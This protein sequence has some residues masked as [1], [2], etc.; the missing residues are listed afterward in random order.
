M[1]HM[2]TTA[3]FLADRTRGEELTVNFVAIREPARAHAS[4]GPHGVGG[5]QLSSRR[6]GW[7]QIRL[8]ISHQ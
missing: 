2:D 7:L 1:Y 8:L 5:W 4:R 3:A 6:A